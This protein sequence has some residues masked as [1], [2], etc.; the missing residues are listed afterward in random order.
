M[1]G[2]MFLALQF[3]IKIFL[4]IYI[5]FTSIFLRGLMAPIINEIL[6]ISKQG[7]NACSH[8]FLRFPPFF[9]KYMEEVFL[10]ICLTAFRWRGFK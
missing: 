6:K 8:F 9:L 3:L 1:I 5:K 4:L 7:W 10:F 2:I